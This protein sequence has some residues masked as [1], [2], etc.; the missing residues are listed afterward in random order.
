M[1]VDA[2]YRQQ[3]KELYLKNGGYEVK[4]YYE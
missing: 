3:E 4:N 1:M 2:D